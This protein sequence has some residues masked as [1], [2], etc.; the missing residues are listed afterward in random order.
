MTHVKERAVLSKIICKYTSV[1]LCRLVH[2][3]VHGICQT[4]FLLHSEELS[5]VI[6]FLNMASLCSLK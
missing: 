1:Q 4:D 5:S 2:I 6:S 3:H